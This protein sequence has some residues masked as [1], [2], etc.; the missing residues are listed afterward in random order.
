MSKC[1]K[2]RVGLIVCTCVRMELFRSDR[3]LE[4]SVKQSP[5]REA[6]SQSTSLQI[7]RVLWNPNINY[8]SQEHVNVTCP[9]PDEFSPHSHA[10]LLPDPSVHNCAI[11]A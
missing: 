8:R 4:N 10:L 6:N 5:S 1:V 9:D 2:T 7:L 11:Y 3:G